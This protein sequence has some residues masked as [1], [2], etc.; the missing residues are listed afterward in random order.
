MENGW[1]LLKRT[2]RV[3]GAGSGVEGEEARPS[4]SGRRRRGGDATAPVLR[5]EEEEKEENERR[6]KGGGEIARR[7]AHLERGGGE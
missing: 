4:A 2:S 6:E 1:G 3:G 7:H 5:E